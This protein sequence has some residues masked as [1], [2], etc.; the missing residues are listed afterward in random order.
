MGAQEL[1]SGLRSGSTR[2]YVCTVRMNEIRQEGQWCHTT[3]TIRHNETEDKIAGE[4]AATMWFPK[5]MIKATPNRGLLFGASE[6]IRSFP[7]VFGRETG[8]QRR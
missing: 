1:V 6:P 4:I 8:C 5:P 3:A 2:K 7:R